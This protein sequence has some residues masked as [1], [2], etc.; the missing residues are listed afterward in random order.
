M[1]DGQAG[2]E[3]ART[4]TAQR[5]GLEGREGGGRFGLMG[6]RDGR[7][8]GEMGGGGD[9]I[10][11]SEEIKQCVPI[12]LHDLHLSPISGLH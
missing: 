1:V 8:T 10:V 11:N 7:G 3:V 12:F 2:R 5:D 9:C 4:E 6:E